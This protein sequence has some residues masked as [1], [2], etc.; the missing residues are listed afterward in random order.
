MSGT[1]EFLRNGAVAEIVLRQPA[2]RNAISAGMWRRIADITEGDELAGV[3]CVVVRGEGDC[4]SA[5]ADIT[6][7]ET[8]R[9]ADTAGD[10]DDLVESTVRRVEALPM[11]VLAAISGPCIGAG[12]SLACGCDLRLAG[13]SAYFAVP[14]AQ[15]GLGYDPRGISRFRRV[16]GDVAA[17][18]ILFTA[19]RMPALRAY[20]IGAVSA[21]AAD[22]EVLSDALALAERIASNAPLTL[23]AAKAALNE[24]T[25]RYQPSGTA[26]AMAADADRSADYAE[27]RAAFA[28]KRRPRFRGV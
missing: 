28:E 27:G 11:P 7:F 23:R 12:A 19:D 14:A 22:G 20:D 10:Y 18:Q 1:V 24:M 5:G 17:R 25:D 2:R 13:R 8:G 26:L 3:S 21:I 6:G 4:F 9:A 15:L 16:F